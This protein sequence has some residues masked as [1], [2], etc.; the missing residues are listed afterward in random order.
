MTA[1]AADEP[2][3]L[4]PDDAFAVL[5]NETRFEIIRTLWEQYEPDDPAN[6]VKFSDLYDGDAAVTFSELYDGV[7]YGDTGNFNYH[8]EQ[9]TDHFVRRTDAGYELTEAG[10]E[11]AR[12]VVAGTV[13]EHP[14]FDATEVDANC[15]RCDAPV[16]VDYENHHVSAAC[17]RCSGIW[18]NADGEDGVLFT[19]SFPPTGL[20]NRTPQDAFH[21]ALAFNLNRIRSFIDGVCPDCSSVVEESLDVCEDHD[22]G[23]RGGCPRCHRQHA[24]EVSEVCH[25]CKSVARGPLSI[26]ILAHPTVTSF[27]HDHG[28]EHRFASWETFRR[29][30][31]VEVAIV[32]D[33]P[34]RS[35]VTVPCEDDR[36][37]LTLDESLSV[38]EAI[39]ETSSV[40][41]Y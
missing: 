31:S 1:G 16:V 19:F 15:P 37:R 18:Q 29:G 28:I 12:A 21:A 41:S 13:R 14:R 11:I 2:T 26:A 23:D 33:D 5:G 36:L 25:G 6:V 24:I 40:R 38:V 3:T 32:D 10:F 39:R 22:P 9:L 20:S 30:Q 4:S 8:L 7:G 34:L 17:S 35:R 27:Y